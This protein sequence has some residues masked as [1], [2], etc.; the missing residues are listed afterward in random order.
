MSETTVSFVETTVS[1]KVIKGISGEVGQRCEVTMITSVDYP[2]LCVV[3][4]SM[5]DA[6]KLLLGGLVASMVCN[7]SA[8]V[9][10]NRYTV[11]V[12]PVITKA[13]YHIIAVPV[14]IQ[15]SH[16]DAC[17]LLSAELVDSMVRVEV[18]L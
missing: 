10:G 16:K 12:T 1:T 17:K 6:A 5:E 18:T 8:D 14:S 9:R 2:N 13:N 3:S 4:V 7:T 11:G 15:V